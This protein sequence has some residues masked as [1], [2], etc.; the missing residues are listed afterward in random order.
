M[1]ELLVIVLTLLLSAYFSGMEMAF[2]SANRFRIELLSNQGDRTGRILSGYLHN[3]SRFIA[4]ILIANNLALVIYGRASGQLIESILVEQAGFDFSGDETGLLL[5]QTLL[6]TLVVLVIGEYLPKALVSNHSL[7]VLR[8]TAWF[9]DL[10]YQLLR[11]IVW[12]TN[13]FT[14]LLLHRILGV[15]NADQNLVF[16]KRDLHAYIMETI[17]QVPEQ[18]TALDAETFSKALDFNQVKV[19]EFMVPRTEIVALP[20]SASIEELRELFIE[21]ELSRIVIYEDTLDHV[22]GYIHTRA[23]FAN[24]S[25]FQDVIQHVMFVPES[26]SAS[27]LLGEFNNRRKSMAIVVDEFGGTAG[28]VTIEDLVETVFG[29]IDDEHDEEDDDELTEE[30]LG[31]D[32]FIFSA[33]LEIDYL[34]ET[35]DLDLPEGEYTT[36]S[37]LV[38]Q[39]AERIP[40]VNDVIDLPGFSI[41]VLTATRNKVETVKLQRFTS[42]E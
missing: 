38:M 30:T 14:R 18:S 19:R 17:Q 15:P 42:H 11:P 4:T 2:F 39:A 33:R 25:K 22:R 27:T 28:L 20:S 1:I 3:A 10:F 8:S 9:M 26:M 37:G 24:P 21:T 34:N 31:P 23:L 29:E 7:T 12:F 32:L 41:T 5:I 36:L 16:S 40:A 35:Y 13:G 6:S